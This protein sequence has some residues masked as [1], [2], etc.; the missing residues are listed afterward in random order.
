M[1]KMLL[2]QLVRY[3]RK[4]SPCLEHEG[5]ATLDEGDRQKAWQLS[6][7]LRLAIALNKER[8]SRI[9]WLKKAKGKT[10]GWSVRSAVSAITAPTLV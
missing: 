8:R 3:Q 9:V 10:F 6:A 1:E 7:L 5:F 2:A 4:A